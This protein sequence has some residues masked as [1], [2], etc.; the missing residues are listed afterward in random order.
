[1]TITS[2]ESFEFGLFVGMF[3]TIFTVLLVNFLIRYFP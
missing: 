2:P 1:M 3:M